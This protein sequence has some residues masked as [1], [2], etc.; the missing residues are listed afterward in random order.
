MRPDA[1]DQFVHLLQF[2]LEHHVC[3]LHFGVFGVVAAVRV[4]LV[5]GF[6]LFVR[7]LQFA[8]DVVD[9]HFD[10]VVLVDCALAAARRPLGHEHGVQDGVGEVAVVD[11]FGVHGQAED[12]RRVL[13]RD[14]V[15]DVGLEVVDGVQ[16]R[17]FLLRLLVGLE[18]ERLAHVEHEVAQLLVQVGVEHPPVPV[19][20]H[21]AALHGFANQLLQRAPWPHF[22]IVFLTFAELVIE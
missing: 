9:G 12:S 19:V 3:E 7:L 11:D 10:R 13:G 6:V 17:H 8:H 21:A 14:V 18:L 22:I 4:D 5:E 16:T 15:L 2:L 20:G 1:D